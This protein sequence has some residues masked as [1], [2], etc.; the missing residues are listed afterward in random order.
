MKKVLFV[1]S[2]VVPFVKTGGLA[3]V[4]GSLPKYFDKE[5]YDVRVV[6][7]K[8]MMIPDRYKDQMEYQTHFYMDLAWRSQYV[9]VVKLVSDGVTFYFIDNEYYFSGDKPY[10]DI[11]WDIEKFSFFCK[12]ALSALPLLDFRPDIIHCHDWQTGL[13]PVYLKDTFSQGEFFQGIKTIMTIHNLKFQ[14]VWDVKT[15]KDI[16][17]LNVSYFAPDKLEAYGDANLLKGGI[18]YSNYVTTVSDSYA[19]EIKT[20]FYGEGLDGLINARA[21][22]LFG[23]VNGL[24]YEEYNPQTDP[25]IYHNY[26]AKNFRKEKIKNKRGLQD[27]M[28]LAHDDKKFMI[29]ICSRLTDQ[30]GFDLI[31]YVIEELCTEDTQLV[32]LGTG[33]EKYEHLFRHYAWKYND[34]VSANIYYSNEISHK[35]YASCDA[36]LMPSLFEPCGLSQLMSLRYGTIPIVRETGGLKDTVQ[37]YNEFEGTGTGFSFANY[38]AHEMLNTIRYA[39]QVFFERKREWNKIIDRG[40]AM[41]YSWNNSARKYEELYDRLLGY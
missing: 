8:Y 23:I 15:V 19:E 17:G 9:G 36:F 26:T 40:M 27:E 32:V 22:D 37:P 29:G 35:L 39:K 14:G 16:T 34:R 18:V 4:A 20:P 3:D 5:K 38:N 25:L 33:D 30:K 13:I 12:A 6:L 41:D 28:G 1:A 31:D 7:P 21:N 2:E 24:D 11:K 10:G